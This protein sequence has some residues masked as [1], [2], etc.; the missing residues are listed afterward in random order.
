MLR[1]Y[2]FS[3]LLEWLLQ[4]CESIPIPAQYQGTKA[5]ATVVQKLHRGTITQTGCNRLC[6]SFPACRQAGFVLFCISPGE[7]RV[8]KQKES[9]KNCLTNLHHFIHRA[10]QIPFTRCNF[11]A[12]DA[13]PYLFTLA[14]NSFAFY[15]KQ[16]A[17]G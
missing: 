3:P 5:E 10:K 4:F 13:L 2:S 11:L 14:E 7:Y 16:S 8:D 15:F 6:G 17:F 9:S 12:L 1:I